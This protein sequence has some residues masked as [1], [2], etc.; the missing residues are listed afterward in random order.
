M[1]TDGF[2]TLKPGD[3]V[4]LKSAAEINQYQL[5]FQLIQPDI[6]PFLGTIVTVRSVAPLRFVELPKYTFG[7]A[8]ISHRAPPT[9]QELAVFLGF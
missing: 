5:V 1:T 7:P 8:A 6:L 3:R 4:Y 9:A 2:E